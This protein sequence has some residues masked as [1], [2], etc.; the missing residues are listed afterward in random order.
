MRNNN[1]VMILA[2]VGAVVVAFIVLNMAGDIFRFVISL[3]TW[4]VA[5][6]L[7][8]RL[9]RGR[10]YGIFMDVLLGLVGG[11]VGH[12]VFS[13]VGLGGISGIPLVGSLIVGIIGAVLFV[14][15]VRLV[16]NENFAR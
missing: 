11:I 5:G 14:F 8:G 1:T 4:M 15:L 6:T 12:I 16:R 10:G 7:A 3:I 9:L 2:I 13:L